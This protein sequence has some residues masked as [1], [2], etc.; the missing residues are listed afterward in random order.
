MKLYLCL[1][2]VLTGCSFSEGL[3]K[4]VQK[5]NSIEAAALSLAKENRQLR[6]RTIQLETELRKYQKEPK[7]SARSIAAERLQKIEDNWKPDELLFVAEIEF[8]REDFEKAAHFYNGILKQFPS[9]EMIDDAF[10]FKAAR[11]TYEGQKNPKKALEIFE[12]ILN[13]YPQSK[14][15]LQSKLWINIIQY[16]MGNKEK[17]KEGILEFQEKYQNTPEWKILEK[18]YEK[19]IK[20]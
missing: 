13:N 3:Q 14:Y 11:S 18:N 16:Q 5:Q 8:E 9:F 17:A 19:I 15:L 1:I 10:L 6:I 4:S 20:K 12:K 7:L 2:L